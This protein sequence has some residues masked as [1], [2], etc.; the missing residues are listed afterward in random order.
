MAIGGHWRLVSGLPQSRT[1][2][3][4]LFAIAQAVQLLWLFGCELRAQTKKA[5][6]STNIQIFPHQPF[7]VGGFIAMSV[8]L[9]PLGGPLLFVLVFFMLRFSRR[10]TFLVYAQEETTK[11]PHGAPRRLS[12][13]QDDYNVYKRNHFDFRLATLHCCCGAVTRRACPLPE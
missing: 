9:D 8:F 12:T 4:I 5:C 11:A 3:N 6:I 7:P 1:P 13:A 10:P 2:Q